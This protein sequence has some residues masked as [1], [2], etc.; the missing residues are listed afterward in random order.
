MES[1]DPGREHVYRAG[2]VVFSQGEP[3]MEMYQIQ[4]GLVRIVR[5]SKSG[6]RE[7]A[8]LGAGEFFG[9]MGLLQGHQRSATAIADLDS[10]VLRLDRDEILEKIR[11][12]PDFVASLLL[13]LCERLDHT[14]S[15]LDEVL[16]LEEGASGEVE[17]LVA[18][19][20]TII[21]AGKPYT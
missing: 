14:N 12:D 21:T 4:A 5:A 3:G 7:L 19:I 16:E 8:K 11:R 15:Y 20:R 1:V 17:E 13:T 6:E 2:E 10:Q 18:R 9:E